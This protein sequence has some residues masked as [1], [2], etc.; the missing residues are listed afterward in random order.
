M[1]N[2]SS[3]ARQDLRRRSGL[4]KLEQGYMGFILNLPWLIGFCIFKVYPLV[5]SMVYRFKD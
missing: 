4:S 1:T 5:Y 3:A 2:G